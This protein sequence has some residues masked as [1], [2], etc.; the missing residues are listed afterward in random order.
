M[1]Y[2]HHRLLRQ[3]TEKHPTLTPHK[4]TLGNEC[5][6]VSISADTLVRHTAM[7]ACLAIHGN[8]IPCQSRGYNRSSPE[9][10]DPTFLPTHR[11]HVADRG[12][13]KGK[14][15]NRPTPQITCVPN[16]R[17]RNATHRQFRRHQPQYQLQLYPFTSERFHA[18]LNSLNGGLS[19]H[20]RQQYT[21]PV[22]RL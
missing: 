12:K 9:R 11:A 8:S 14:T 5:L 7:V 16:K 13:G 6:Q 21:L 4:K 22:K 15:A 19:R 2:S 3:C 17:I 20:T 18:L 10:N 1:A